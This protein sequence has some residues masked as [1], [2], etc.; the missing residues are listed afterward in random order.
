MGR[1]GNVFNDVPEVVAEILVLDEV[2][3]FDLP[4]IVMLGLFNWVIVSH[5][6]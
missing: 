5:G 2:D 4:S 6:V 3:N 1:P